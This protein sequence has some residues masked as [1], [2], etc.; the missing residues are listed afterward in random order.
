[1]LFPT[2]IGKIKARQDHRRKGETATQKR[3][4]TGVARGGFRG[5]RIVTELGRR[6]CGATRLQDGVQRIDKAILGFRFRQ[7]HV[8]VCDFDVFQIL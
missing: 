7:E 5:K 6:G 3:P 2:F 8:S 1:M 4:R